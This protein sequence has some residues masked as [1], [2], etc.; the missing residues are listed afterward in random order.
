M[1]VMVIYSINEAMGYM[2]LKNRELGEKWG[3]FKFLGDR[4]FGFVD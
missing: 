4:I 3:T 2:H 1:I